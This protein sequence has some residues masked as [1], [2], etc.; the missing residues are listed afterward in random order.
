V[1]QLRGFCALLVVGLILGLT[2]AAYADPPDPTWIG[3][4]WDDDD[5]DNVVTFICGTSAIAVPCTVDAGPMW[6]PVARGEPWEP[7]TG[8]APLCSD[9]SSRAPPVSFLPLAS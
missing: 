5:F 8:P 6:A 1:R 3:G 7:N 2:P 4:Y 9:A